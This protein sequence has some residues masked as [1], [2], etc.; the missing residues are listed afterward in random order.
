MH[1]SRSTW[2]LRLH[3]WQRVREYAVPPPMIE[4]ATAR[5]LVGDWAGAC[6]AARVDVDV[7]MRVLRRRYGVG[8]AAAVRTDLRHFAPDLLRWHM[9]RVTP[10]GLLRPGT[11]STLARYPLPDGGAGHLVVRTPPAW[12]AGPQR[13]SLAWWDVGDR[14]AP[15]PDP[16]FRLDLHRY[17]WDARHSAELSRRSGVG[18]DGVVLADR[19]PPDGI[20]TDWAVARWAAEAALLVAVDGVPDAGI[21]VRLGAQRLVLR[22]DGQGSP[23]PP[24]PEELAALL[25]G[26][27][28]NRPR[29]GARQPGRVSAH[30]PAVLPNA[31][32]W[33][34]PDVLLLSAGLITP[35]D[36]HPLVA[37]ALAPDTA[38]PRRVAPPQGTRQVECRGSVHRLAVVDG[39]LTALDHATDEIRHEELLAQLGGTPLPCL[40]VIDQLHRAPTALADVRARLDHGDVESALSVV[41]SL[42]G[43]EAVLRSGDLQDELAAAA[44]G[45]SAYG[46]YRAGLLPAL[47]H[48]DSAPFPGRAF[49][50]DRAFRASFVASATPRRQRDRR[51]RRLLAATH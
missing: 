24:A 22:L 35:G 31:A 39:V 33:V 21:L 12:A 3:S 11:T 41:E 6:A 4:T 19:T 47:L 26:E 16:R 49:S 48:P 17:L 27:R 36:L 42:L 13:M 7:D 37:D 40:H 20:P 23:R 28:T 10:D 25:G 32:T 8:L 1:S 50:A 9:P 29:S 15:H 2:N 14:A 51:S 38:R 30:P 44:A 5:R 46:V 43:P 45:R 34:P 18:P